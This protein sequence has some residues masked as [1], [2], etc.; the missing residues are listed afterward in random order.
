MVAAPIVKAAA[1]P[2]SMS[3]EDR[4]KTLFAIHRLNIG[5]K[6]WNDT[7][8]RYCRWFYAVLAALLVFQLFSAAASDIFE[9]LKNAQSSLSTSGTSTDAKSGDPASMTIKRDTYL[10]AAEHLVGIAATIPFVGGLVR[11]KP[12]NSVD[13]QA[14]TA[15]MC[16]RLITSF[17]GAYLLPLLYGMLGAVALILRRI[18]RAAE[19]ND[20]DL[21]SLRKKLDLRL[22]VGALAG[23]SAGWLIQPSSLPGSTLSPL[24]LAFV[25]GYAA[26][27]VFAAM[28][29][30]VAAFSSEQPEKH[31]STSEP[32]EA[33]GVDDAAGGTAHANVQQVDTAETADPPDQKEPIRPMSNALANDEMED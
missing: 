8:R 28:D 20:S 6:F 13:A 15:L 25:A 12:Q 18:S 7:R 4:Q 21:N 11:S 10:A 33:N 31:S 3:V 30:I 17:L 19:S 32:P 29:R 16:L 9:N 14:E 2:A 26:E 27:L 1:K 24:A 23:L 22:P 5:F